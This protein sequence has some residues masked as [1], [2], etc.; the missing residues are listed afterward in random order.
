MKGKL[1]SWIIGIVIVIILLIPIV[2]NYV[3]TRNIE[4]VKY[5]DFTSNLA[6]TDFSLTYVGDLSDN[7]YDSI[8]KSLLN[9]R[10]KYDATVNS[11]DKTKLSDENWKSISNINKDITDSAYVFVKEGEIVYAVSDLSEEKLDVLI[12]KYKNNVIPENEIYYKTFTTYKEYMKLVDSKKV[13]MTVF[14]RNTCSWC[15]K[16]KPVYNDVAHEYNLDIYYVDSDSFNST[17][18]SKILNSDVTIPGKCAN[19]TDVKLSSG[20]GTPLT[21]FT[22][23][24]KSI[25]C[26]SGYTNKEGLIKVLKDVGLIK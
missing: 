1:K 3:K 14:G 12:N 6:G 19:G 7:K 18:Y 24:G 22:K 9:L 11:M 13:T 2:V 10:S 8:E 17:E 16:F 21:I 15:N 20:F 23:N 25:D 26:I 5:D 4:T